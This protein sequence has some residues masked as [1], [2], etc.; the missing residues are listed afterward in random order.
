M[1][2]QTFF[3]TARGKT[4]REAFDTATSEARYEHGH[5]GYTGTLAEK[6]SYTMIAM[7]TVV[8]GADEKIAFRAAYNFANELI[9]NGD[10]RVD[11]KWGPAG[12]LQYSPGKF[13]FFGWA[14]S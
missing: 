11:D 12:C 1:G 2:A 4:A 7:P 9:N 13:L 14:S 6:S 10:S 5:G 8:G 3:E